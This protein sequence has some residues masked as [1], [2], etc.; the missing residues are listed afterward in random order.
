MLR[1]CTMLVALGVAGSAHAMTWFP[2]APGPND[3]TY[4][5]YADRCESAAP[6]APPTMKPLG[7]FG[8]WRLEITV[9]S[10]TELCD[11]SPDHIGALHAIEI[12]D[13]IDG[14]AVQT[15][16]IV[17]HVAVAPDRA[18]VTLRRPARFS[19]PASVSG[20]WTLD[21]AANQGLLLTLDDLRRLAVGFF[22]FDA[23][24]RPTWMT[25]I[26]ETLPDDPRLFIPM[27]DV[28]SGQFAGTPAAPV[29]P[30]DWGFLDLSYAG[31]GRLDAAWR[32][33]ATTGL[34]SHI[35]TFRQ[36]TSAATCNLEDY[37]TNRGLRV[38]RVE[39]RVVP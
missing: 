15:I 6:V 36:L 30:R 34:A 7:P 23:Q 14:K 3:P 17:E 39:F 22:T 20:T 1:T 33:R 24:G 16:E 38:S 27:M 18:V 8:A 9:K 37:A 32:P 25:G 10:L 29:P 21:G 28:P 12:P 11:P 19:M 35:G 2:A 4:L 26:A 5:I 13:E 31:C